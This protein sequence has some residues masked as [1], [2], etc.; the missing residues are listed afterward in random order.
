MNPIDRLRAAIRTN[1]DRRGVLT[2][3]MD[4]VLAAPTTEN[5]DLT[6]TETT[7]LAEVRAA[8]ASCD[9]ERGRLSAELDE[10]VAEQERRSQIAALTQS[11]GVDVSTVDTDVRVGDGPSTYRQGGEHSF[12]GDL[13]SMQM[14]GSREATERLDRHSQ[15]HRATVTAD[16]SGVV[17]PQYL[18]DLFAPIARAGSPMYNALNRV[19]LPAVGT[20][21]VIPRG[22]TG[23]AAAT[24][25]EG[26]AYNDADY[27]A[28][29][30]TVSVNLITAATDISRT[31]F[32]RG[33]SVVDQI[34][35]PDMIADYYTK[36]DAQL[37]SGNGTAPQHRGVLNVGGITTVAYTD[38]SPTVGEVWPKLQDAIGQINALRFAGATAVVMHPRRWAWFAAAVD[39]TGRPLGIAADAPQNAMGLGDVAVYG[40]IVG[41]LAG[42]PVITDANIPTNTGAGTNQDPIIVVRSSDFALMDDGAPTRFTFE[43]AIATA[44]GQVRLAVGGFSAF[45]AG[46]YPKS[47]AVIN[48]TGLVP[49]AF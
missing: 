49:P 15:E 3:D 5:R 34:L 24:T 11:L 31:L 18:V 47:I 30:D 42:L 45:H 43:Q 26:A 28:T 10:L 39:S 8:V 29:D 12:L 40:Q 36:F 35:F 17:P 23:L 22:T 1:L 25:A 9:E 38:A 4:A 46:R 2:A 44:P 19:G 20:S 27:E 48:G 7:R 37:I 13:Y 41:S 33:G 16:L 6:E 14:R 32:E 21:L